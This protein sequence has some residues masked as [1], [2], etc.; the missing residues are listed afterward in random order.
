MLASAL[1]ILNLIFVVFFTNMIIFE[2]VLRKEKEKENN[3]LQLILCH[4]MA[5]A[6]FSLMNC[7]HVGF[8]WLA[9]TSVT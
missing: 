2:D 9:L 1:T 5:S 7:G 6:L 3:L 8:V 4:L